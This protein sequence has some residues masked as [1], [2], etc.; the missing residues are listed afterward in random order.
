MK[1]WSCRPVPQLPGTSSAPRVHD[2]STGQLEVLQ[3]RGGRA[4]LYVCGITPYDATHMGH[5]ATYVTFDLLNRAWRDAGFAVDYVQNV[6]DVDD[7]LLERANAT[8]V[9]WRELAASQTELFRT[10]MT[11][12]NV[13]PPDHYVGATEA[14]EWIVPAVERLVERGLAYRVPAGTDQDGNPA[15][16]GDVYFDVAAAGELRAEDP[17]AWVVGSTCRLDTDR[18]RMTPLFAGH[19][20]DPDRTGKHDPLDPLLWRVERAGEPSWDGASLGAGR[21]GWHIECSVIALQHLPR[22]FTV[23]GGGSDLAFPHHDM[24]AGHAYALSGEPMAEHFVHTAMVGLN[25]EKMSKSKGNLVLVSTLRRD[26]V[27]PAAIRLAILSNHYRTDWFWTDELLEQSRRRLA[28]WREAAARP[29]TAGADAMLQ[30]V[31]AALGEDLNAPAALIAV[32]AWA[33]RNLG[34]AA[35]RGAAASDEDVAL[36]RHTVTALLGIEL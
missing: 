11:A 3:A 8:G 31:R 26:G 17:D 32:D 20:G 27:D 9:D 15:P 29:E 4:A 30:A 13:L 1:S 6:T 28:T 18:E 12:L 7:P 5:A 14:V 36:A 23:Q 25:G 22:P 10:D 16:A 24:G 2:T 34:G 21:P 33:A 19:G 35:A